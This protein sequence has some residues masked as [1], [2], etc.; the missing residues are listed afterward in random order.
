MQ[1]QVVAGRDEAE[2]PRRGEH[3][4]GRRRSGPRAP[5]ETSAAERELDQLL[6]ERGVTDW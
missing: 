3:V 4:G 5:H 6:A 2:L 1:L